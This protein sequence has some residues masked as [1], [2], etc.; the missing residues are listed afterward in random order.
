MGGAQPG[1]HQCEVLVPPRP[2]GGDCKE[3]G[4]RFRE[5]PGCS[6]ERLGVQ[7]GSQARLV[8]P[9]RVGLGFLPAESWVAGPTAGGSSCQVSFG[10][11]KRVRTCWLRK[12][13]HKVRVVPRRDQSRPNREGHWA[14]AKGYWRQW[15]DFS[16]GLR[17]VSPPSLFSM[18][19]RGGF[20][21]PFQSHQLLTPAPTPFLL[22]LKIHFY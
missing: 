4:S 16:P 15:G 12:A 8:V 1:R 10:L 13:L 19:A 20:I 6:G 2:Q 17:L 22:L 7:N 14:G 11:H 21:T 9:G 18:L 5:H 3:R